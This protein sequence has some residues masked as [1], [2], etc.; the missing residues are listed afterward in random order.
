MPRKPIDYSNTIIY[1]LCCNDITI[2][3]IYVGHTTNWT[4]RKGSHKTRCNNPNNKCYNYYVYQFIREHGCW[5]NWSMVEIEKI[6]CIDSNDARKHERR[7]LELLGATLNVVLPTQT[8]KEYVENNKEHIKKLQQDWYIKN[9]EI[10]ISR[11][12]KR[13]T[14]NIEYIKEYNKTYHA[15]EANKERVKQQRKEKNNQQKLKKT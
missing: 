1:K 10:T 12:S 14:Q 4:K 7:Y 5:D 8:K 3:D 13:Y 15:N 9:K 6:N 11:A 2:T